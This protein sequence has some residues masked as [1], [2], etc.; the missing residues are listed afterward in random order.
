MV[1]YAFASSTQ[2]IACWRENRNKLSA[3]EKATGA[4]MWSTNQSRK[5]WHKNTCGNFINGCCHGDTQKKK[6]KK[7]GVLKKMKADCHSVVIILVV[8][9]KVYNNNNMPECF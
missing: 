4:W 8:E 2:L 5:F 6:G 3:N 1:A 7:F 9:S